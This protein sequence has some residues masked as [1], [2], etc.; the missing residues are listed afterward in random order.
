MGKVIKGIGKAVGK[1]A[2]VAAPFA[3]LIPGIGPLAA[4]GLGAGGKA[5]SRAL[6]GQNTFGNGGTEAILGAAAAGAGGKLANNFLGGNVASKVGTALKNQYI[7]GG[8]LDIGKVLGT[9]GGVSSMIGQGKQRKSAQDFNNAQ[10]AQRN[11]LMSKILAGRD[12]GL[13]SPNL[14]QQSSATVGG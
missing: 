14:N 13:P 5:L 12:Y 8:Q 2:G 1:V 10:I 9:A 11:A 4:A 7:P 3:G 6:G